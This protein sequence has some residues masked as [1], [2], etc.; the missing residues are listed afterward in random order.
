MFE[1]SQLDHSFQQTVRR[2]KKDGK[3]ILLN[4]SKPLLFSELTMFGH[5][6]FA[7]MHF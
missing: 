2:E 3:D 6:I 1:Q 5:S 7:F 4:R